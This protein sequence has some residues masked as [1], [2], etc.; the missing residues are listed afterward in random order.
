VS[1]T[2]GWGLDFSIYTLLKHYL[3]LCLNLPK[4]TSPAKMASLHTPQKI[5]P[6]KQLH[7]NQLSRLLQSFLSLYSN[8]TIRIV[9]M[10]LV[11]PCHLPLLRLDHTPAPSPPWFDSSSS[12]VVLFL[13][14]LSILCSRD[15][16]KESDSRRRLAM[17]LGFSAAATL[18]DHRRHDGATAGK[19]R[20]RADTATRQGSGGP[21]R[22]RCTSLRLRVSSKM[23]ALLD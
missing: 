5:Y 12:Q 13:F 18:A 10:V 17:R 6:E 7:R 21:G 8:L 9:C 19:R 1:F 16:R 22:T 23:Q 20:R 14:F 2:V 15:R 3:F 4:K 11:S